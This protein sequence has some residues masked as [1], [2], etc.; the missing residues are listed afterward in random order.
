VSKSR[1]RQQSP[2]KRIITYL[3]D[4]LER[5]WKVEIEGFGERRLVGHYMNKSTAGGSASRAQKAM[6]RRKEQSE[7]VG[8][9][10]WR[11]IAMDALE[12][13]DAVEHF[14]PR[15]ELSSGQKLLVALLDRAVLDLN[16]PDTLIRRDAISFFER[17][18][19]ADVRLEKETGA[20]T[21][22]KAASCL[23]LDRPSI[24]AALSARIEESKRY[25]AF[26]RYS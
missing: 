24:V 6:L 9:D 25:K 18:E 3:G 23:N 20:I 17:S 5:P 10:I 21:L 22:T 16:C 19:A 2:I 15:P 13:G 26:G 11:G 14:R 1:G 7:P 8:R 12:E 4:G